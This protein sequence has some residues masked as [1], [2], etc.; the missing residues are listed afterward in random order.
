MKFG[1]KTR[2][3]LLVSV[4]LLLC[5]CDVILGGW[6]FSDHHL[7]PCRISGTSTCS[8]QPMMI[9]CSRRNALV[10]LVIGASSSSIASPFVAHAALVP[11]MIILPLETSSG[12]TIRIEEIGGGLDLLLSPPRY[13]IQ[14]YFTHHP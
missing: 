13:H 6:H 4:A 14:T 5:S 9:C 2:L 12:T 3:H 10:G 7:P 1:M 11:K 8:Q